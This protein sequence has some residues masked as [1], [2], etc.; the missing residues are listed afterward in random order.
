MLLT[1]KGFLVL[2][3]SLFCFNS[4]FQPEREIERESRCV[5]KKVFDALIG[6]GARRVAKAVVLER[7]VRKRTLVSGLDTQVFSFLPVLLVCW[8]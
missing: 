1:D 6:L 8:K 2:S 5:F 3:G 7:R 4:N